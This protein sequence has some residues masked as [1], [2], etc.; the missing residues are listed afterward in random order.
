LPDFRP[1]A[2]D[3]A[4]QSSSCRLPGGA[5]EEACAE[6]SATAMEPASPELEPAGWEAIGALT[7]GVPPEQID[8]LKAV[9][10][11]EPV[12]PLLHALV[13]RSM[14]D[15][16]VRA[17][18]L[19]ALVQ[20]GRPA[21]EARDVDEVLSFLEPDA[22]AA[23]MGALRRSGWLEHDPSVGTVVTDAGRWAFDILAFLHKRVVEAELLPT[24]AGLDYALQIGV[25]PVRHL[26]S[27]RARL[28]ALRAEIDAARASHSEI[29]LR[30]TARRIED[31][32]RL[33]AQIR[34]ALDRV[35]LDHVAA[36]AVAREIHG[37]LAQLHGAGS[38]LH[39]A[40][41]EVGRQYLVLTGGLTTEQIVRALMSRSRDE[42]ARV[43]RDALLPVVT[44]P[45]LVTTDVLASAAEQQA[46]RER[47]EPERL[48]WEEPDE[49]PR[50]TFDDSA[51]EDVRSLLADLAAVV[52]A[53]RAAPLVDVVAQ[54]SKAESFLRLSL[55]PLV[56]DAR[57]GEGFAGQLGALPLEVE[58]SGDGW[59]RPVE[60]RP[61]A[62]L[63]PGEVVPRAHRESRD[64]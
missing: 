22:R 45:P 5:P 4:V 25:D 38:E 17:A 55:L 54:G 48:A 12:Y 13:G 15:F 64:G 9:R 30:R 27:M 51:P 61:I 57:A 39:S 52:G 62:S 33:S 28:N 24:V 21:F 31:T 14:R 60:G 20:S 35:P 44:P 2:A 29:V 16:L 46:L 34:A 50:A 18:A 53:G 19:E 56:G 11:L 3:A 6:P 58:A 1:D 49:A 7:G 10:T 47:P 26:L 43:A 42:L 41:T 40:V 8:E 23:T 63:T 37:L 32:L 59:A 36:R